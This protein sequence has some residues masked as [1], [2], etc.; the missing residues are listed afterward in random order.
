MLT[1]ILIFTILNFIGVVTYFIGKFNEKYVIEDRE[2]YQ[3]MA[4]YY[5]QYHDEQGN[6][7]NHELAGGT[8]TPYYGFFQD[9]LEEDP[10]EEEEDE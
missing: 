6:E 4:D 8:G 2:V 7:L 5:L 9:Y 3:A 1:L 10:D